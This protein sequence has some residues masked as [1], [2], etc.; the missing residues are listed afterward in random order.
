MIFVL[1]PVSGKIVQI[2]PWRFIERSAFVAWRGLI[3]TAQANPRNTKS[4]TNP[5]A[6]SAKTAL[7][8]VKSMVLAQ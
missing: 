6:I 8:K 2:T 5:K 4:P 1:V 7:L 3:N